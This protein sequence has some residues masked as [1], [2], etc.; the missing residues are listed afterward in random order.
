MACD[1]DNGTPL[2]LKHANDVGHRDIARRRGSHKGVS[3]D[4]RAGN[5]QLASN[6]LARFL[7]S[8]GAGR[9]RT[10]FHQLF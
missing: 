8:L 9:S 1:H 7:Q 4:F 5:G 2:T 10:Q 3:L 6:I